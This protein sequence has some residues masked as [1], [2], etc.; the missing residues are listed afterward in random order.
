MKIK[1]GLCR[2]EIVVADDLAD[3]Q[4][5]LC[6]YCGG[7]SEYRKPTRIELPT[8]GAVRENSGKKSGGVIVQPSPSSTKPKLSIIRPERPTQM[9][10]TE[11]QST[12]AVFQHK[13]KPI[14]RRSGEHPIYYSV[15]ILV[16]GI[17]V[18]GIFMLNHHQANEVR[19]QEE[20]ARQ[21]EFERK[22]VEE[23]RRLAREE[24]E[25]K[26]QEELRKTEEES[27]RAKAEEERKRAE[28]LAAQKTREESLRKRR[29][30]L[31]G[32]IAQVGVVSFDY[33]RNCPKADRPQ[34][35]QEEK[36]YACIIPKDRG[37]ADVLRIVAAPDK[38]MYVERYDEVGELTHVSLDD[39]HAAIKQSV[40]LILSGGKGWICG[41]QKEVDG[42]P[43]VNNGS[44]INPAK[45][46]LGEVY[47]FLC[48]HSARVSAISYSVFFE[49]KKG[50]RDFVRRVKFGDVVSAGDVKPIIREDLQEK[51]E[52]KRSGRKT[53]KSGFKR[54]VVFGAVPNIKRPLTGPI[55]I[56]Y[57]M[58]AYQGYGVDY[59][60]GY[61]N[62][63]GFHQTWSRKSSNSAGTRE[64]EYL[65][66]R[67]VAEREDIEE[68]NWRSQ[69]YAKHLAEVHFEVPEMEVEK[70]LFSGKF[71]FTSAK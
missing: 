38:E 47:E 43:V 2:K 11:T 8:G 22:E 9:T 57:A 59:K 54:T 33:W 39:F 68:A 13:I 6:P 40:Y 23:Q 60:A 3:G 61:W 42:V 4:H 53:K 48:Q 65:N 51:A 21:R 18:A 50:N 44:S 70:T 28:E 58:P 66:L 24:Q 5:I 17:A 56:P 26:R 29:D 14:K 16:A 69:Q 12:S 52:A 41:V 64:Q 37:R 55:V 67:A 49:D 35:V 46:E 34:S 71:Y 36:T 20:A 10:S 31:A 30:A 15:A 25:R 45:V 63:D 32:I 7:K 62:R 27:K 1:C 19:Q